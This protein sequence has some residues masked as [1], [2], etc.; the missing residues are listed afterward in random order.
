MENNKISP[1]TVEGILE[2]FPNYGL[3][4][5]CEK[6]WLTRSQV[7]KIIKD[8]YPHMFT[9]CACNEGKFMFCMVDCCG[10]FQIKF[11]YE[12]LLI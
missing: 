5:T 3:T 7:M 12:N 8:E 9:Y 10:E 11:E 4:K 2:Y 6:F 1:E